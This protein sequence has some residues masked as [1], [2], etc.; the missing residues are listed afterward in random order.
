M[1]D[2]DNRNQDL[3][4]RSF[5][6]SM[7]EQAD[8]SGADL[9]GV[10]LS[11]ARLR[12]ADFTG[13]Q[14]G[15]LP[16]AAIALLI[17]SLLIVAATGWMIGWTSGDLVAGLG[18]ARW[19]EVL[20]RLIA[21]LVIGFF[22]LCV[23]AYG[24]KRA[25]KYGAIALVVGFGF[26]YVVIGLTS[27]DFQFD[28]DGQVIGVLLLLFASVISGG[29]AQVV[30]GSFATGA[31]LVVGLTGGFAAGR[32][33]GGLAGVVVSVVLILLAKRVLRNDHRDTFARRLVH[34]IVS[35]R[36][37]RFTGAD[38]R[39]ADFTGTQLVQSDLTDAVLAGAKLAAVVGWRPL[40]D[41]N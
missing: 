29:I 33:G 22:I 31:I 36:G 21:M 6:G 25:M 1:T 3:R 27:Q 9:R 20:G 32:G 19:E 39:G 34:Q 18:D 8:F 26:N 37:T 11:R 24:L 14:L 40:V 16:W 23:V 28:R 5:A 41:A 2:L 30:G 17:G 10:D 38:L 12:N 7:L 13:A 4:G 35:K 15:L